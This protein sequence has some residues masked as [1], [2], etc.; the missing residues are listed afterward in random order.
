MITLAIF[1]AILAVFLLWQADRKKQ[2]TG[3]P[4]GRVVYTDTRKWGKTEAPLYNAVLNLTGKPDYLV[5]E[6]EALIP[7]EVKSGWAPSTPYEGHI[8]QLAAYCLLVERTTGNRPSHGILRYRNRT[9]AVDYTTVLE[10][11]LLDLLAE[12]RR[13]ER[14]GEIK[15]SHESPAR[16]IRCGYRSH[17][18]QHL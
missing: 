18:D 15:R 5:V 10:S 7:V 12:M 4:L 9:F 14:S 6:G 13:A 17:C 1:L 8:H 2:E 11:R 16:C 3:L